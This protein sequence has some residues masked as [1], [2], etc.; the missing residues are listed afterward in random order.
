M[1]DACRGGGWVFVVG[2]VVRAVHGGRGGGG[3]EGVGEGG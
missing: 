3:E 2:R 1:V